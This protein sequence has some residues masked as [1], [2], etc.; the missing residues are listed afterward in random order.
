MEIFEALDFFLRPKILRLYNCCVV[1][2]RDCII[3]W[4]AATVIIVASWRAATVIVVASW[5]AATILMNVFIIVE[6]L[7]AMSNADLVF[8]NIKICHN[9]VF[10]NIFFVCDDYYI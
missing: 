10:G 5:R 9:L 6:T 3:S 4:R 8:V 7:R 2:C 1:A